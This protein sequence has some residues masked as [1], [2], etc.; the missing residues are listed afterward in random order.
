MGFT[1]FM[2]Y[3]TLPILVKAPSPIGFGGGS[4]LTSSAVLLP[5]TIVFLIISPLVSKI[6]SKFGNLKPF[7]VANSISLI[8]FAGIFVSHSDEFQVG[9]N[10]TI[11]ATGLAMIN[12]I[13]MNV[14]LLITP[15]NFGGVVVGVVQ[16]FIFTGMALSPIISGLYMQNYQTQSMDGLEDISLP[17]SEAYQLIFLTAVFASCISLAM[18]IVIIKKV[19]SQVIKI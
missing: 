15:K 11:I 7:I 10:L 8:G 12:T 14:I 3:Q 1:M 17:S 16:V 19:P 18:A 6:I 4:S 2:I 13:A 9:L 5:F